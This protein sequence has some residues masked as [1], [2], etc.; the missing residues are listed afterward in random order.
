M[1]FRS[2]VPPGIYYI[3]AIAD[4]TGVQAENNEIN[5][6]L[7]TVATITVSRDVDLVMNA[8]STNATLVPAGGSFTIVNTETNNGTTGM[9]V[10]SNIVRFYLSTDATITSTDTL[11]GSRVVSGALAAGA[12][13]S[14]A[15]TT[16]TV[17]ATL[18]LGTYFIGAIADATGVQPETNEINNALAGTTITV[19]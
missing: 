19:N 17:P 4:A 11:I 18:A 16:V 3:G 15:T 9:T 1:L 12:T 7:A 14:S 5:N 6:A 2:T 10:T 8:I 13:S